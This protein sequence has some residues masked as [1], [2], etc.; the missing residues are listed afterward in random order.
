MNCLLKTSEYRSG[1]GLL[2]AKTHFV[3]II[4]HLFYFS[5]NFFSREQAKTKTRRKPYMNCSFLEILPVG[6]A[7]RGWKNSP[8]KQKS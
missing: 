8:V 2:F 4:A 7:V 1:C 5:Y 6:K 3:I